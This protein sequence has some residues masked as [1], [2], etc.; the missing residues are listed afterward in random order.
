MAQ[1]KIGVSSSSPLKY[2][3]TDQNTVPVS[4]FSRIPTAD[5]KNFPIGQIV[6]LKE[7]PTTGVEGDV[8]CLSKISSGS[9]SW[10]KLNAEEVADAPFAGSGI[11]NTSVAD[12]IS[13]LVYFGVPQ[14]ASDDNIDIQNNLGAGILGLHF[15]PIDQDITVTSLVFNIISYTTS[16]TLYFGLYSADTGAP[17]TLFADL[18]SIT[19]SGTGNKELT[20]DAVTIP[21][22]LYFIG[23]LLDDTDGS[24]AFNMRT[25]STSVMYSYTLSAAN[26]TFGLKTNG[27]DYTALPADLSEETLVQYTVRMKVGLKS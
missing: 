9:A 7:S 24:A 22:G 15:F 10:V 13:G 3:G 12:V 4:Y 23:Y 25:L 5:D 11:L 1:K 18:G 8:Y 21:A 19:V 20:F 26:G 27:T 17:T 6:V 14:V 2:L 16:G